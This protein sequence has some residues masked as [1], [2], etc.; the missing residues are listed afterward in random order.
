[1]FSFFWKKLIYRFD[2]FKRSILKSKIDFFNVEIIS[3]FVALL[4]PLFEL[5]ASSKA[6]TPSPECNNEKKAFQ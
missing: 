5:R 6:H 3:L 1:M 2:Y 4:M